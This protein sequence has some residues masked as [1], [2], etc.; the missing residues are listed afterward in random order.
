MRHSL[1]KKEI[2]GLLMLLVNHTHLIK[3]HDQYNIMYINRSYNRGG[4][5]SGRRGGATDNDEGEL[6]RLT[7]WKPYQ[8]AF[9]SLL[10]R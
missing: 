5:A 8:L 1:L 7:H 9:S 10:P 6:D 2:H 3:S 4:K